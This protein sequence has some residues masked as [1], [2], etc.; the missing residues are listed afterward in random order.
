M[1]VWGAGAWDVCV[2]I[3]I[4]VL[5]EANVANIY[6]GVRNPSV[7]TLC[8]SLFPKSPLQIP[9]LLLRIDMPNDIIRQAHDLVPS[10]VR[11]GREPFRVGL[12]LEGVAGEVYA[13]V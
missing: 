2:Y 6:V 4:Y 12:V 3:Y 8:R 1:V 5:Q 13:C 11:H 7:G 10:A 9:L